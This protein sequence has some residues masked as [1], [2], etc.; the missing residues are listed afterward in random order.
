MNKKMV[1]G[2]DI[3]FVVKKEVLNKTKEENLL[4][5]ENALEKNG[6]FKK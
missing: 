4:A 3:L 6:L 5:I 1:A 2:H